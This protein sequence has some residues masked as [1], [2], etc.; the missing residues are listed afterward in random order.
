[1]NI[2]MEVLIPAKEYPGYNVHTPEE[3]A[4][5]SPVWHDDIHYLKPWQILD[6][7]LFWS[8]PHTKGNFTVF[9]TGPSSSILDLGW[10]FIQEGEMYPGDSALSVSQF[11]GRGQKGRSWISP[12][13]NLY[14]VLRIVYPDRSWEN[15]TSLLTG[16][17]LAKSLQELGWDIRIKWPNDLLYQG[18]KTGGILVEAKDSVILSGIGI[19]LFSSPSDEELGDEP[20]MPAT[21]LYGNE[22][23]PS[24]LKL[25]LKLLERGQEIIRQEIIPGS[26]QQFLSSLEPY[27]AYLNEEVLVITPG[28]DPFR[29]VFTGLDSNGGLRILTA[30]GEKTLMSAEILPVTDN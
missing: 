25:W 8:S 11:A 26:V 5:I 2:P 16:Y 29:A 3:I 14:A 22:P 10:S 28:F 30:G 6:E 1:M 13:G 4:Q 21:H 12:P 23:G 15:L 27:L 17:L 7:D 18:K 20:V 9:V 19:N 24:P